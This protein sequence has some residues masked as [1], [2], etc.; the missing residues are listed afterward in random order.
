ME[1]TPPVALRTYMT[2]RVGV[3]AVIVALGVAVGWEIALQPDSCVQRSLSAYYYTPVRPVFVGA[4]LTIGFAMITMW[5]K[6]FVEDAALNLAGL[7]LIVVAFVPT[8][9]ANYCSLPPELRAT[10]VDPEQKQVS[11]NALISAN[12]DTVARSFTAL[13]VVAFLSLVLALVVGLVM[14]SKPR[15]QRPTDRAMIGFAATWL[16]ALIAWALYV[17]AYQDAGDPDSFFNHE[18]HALSANVGVGL[19][20]VAVLA[21]AWE[22]AQSND[23][24]KAWWHVRPWRQWDRWVWLYGV[25]AVLMVASAAVLKIGDSRGMFWGWVDVHTTFLVEAIL[26]VLLGA[27]WIIQ[28]IERRKDGAPTYL[29]EAPRSPVVDPGGEAVLLADPVDEPV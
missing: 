7:L 29:A 4:L 23:P 18:L 28:T 17:L 5:G 20:I 27:Y 2:I 8:L 1:P 14:R 26:I 10:G 3:V 9:D 25:L 12:A 24:T 13:M 19:V 16:L 11:D 15:A 22:K 21:A 6:T